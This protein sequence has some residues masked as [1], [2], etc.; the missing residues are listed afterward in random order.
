MTRTREKTSYQEVLDQFEVFPSNVMYEHVLGGDF[1]NM[2]EVRD[3]KYRKYNLMSLEIAWLYEK[4]YLCKGWSRKKK[5]KI[6][7]RLK[8]YFKNMSRRFKDEQ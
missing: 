1:E 5:R 7:N 2:K 3:E 4:R 8:R 6:D